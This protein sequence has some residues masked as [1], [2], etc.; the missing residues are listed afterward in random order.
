MGECAEGEEERMR[1]GRASTEPAVPG[2]GTDEVGRVVERWRHFVDPH[3]QAETALESHPLVL[4]SRPVAVSNAGVQ[5]LA[6]ARL[7]RSASGGR[8]TVGCNALFGGAG[9]LRTLEVREGAV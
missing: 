7:A 5:P 8:V 3:A 6:R 2:H 4:K 9:S 1:P